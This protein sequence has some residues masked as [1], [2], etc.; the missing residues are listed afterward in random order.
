MASLTSLWSQTTKILNKIPGADFPLA[1]RL[2]VAYP[3]WISGIGKMGDDL[4]TLNDFAVYPFEE[5]YSVPFLSPE[6]AAYGAMLGE[7]ILPVLLVIG[8]FTR[9]ASAGLLVM[10]GVILISYPDG[11]K[12]TEF[13]AWV[14]PLVALLLRGPGK[15]SLDHLLGKFIKSPETQ[16]TL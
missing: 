14:V 9:F 7:T 16:K 3:F 10:V 11:F 15:I 13:V 12:L 1:V 6:M 4:F 5:E 2:A 8:L